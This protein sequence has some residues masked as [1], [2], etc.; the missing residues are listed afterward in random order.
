MFPLTR[1]PFWTPIFDPQPFMASKQKVLDNLLMCQLGQTKSSVSYMHLAGCRLSIG[2]VWQLKAL[3]DLSTQSRGIQH[4][5]FSRKP[6]GTDSDLFV[7]KAA[8]PGTEVLPKRLFDCFSS[9][10]FAGR[11]ALCC[12]F[13]F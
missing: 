4:P 7:R 3:P 6:K 8:S 10:M 1:V 5:F 13:Q 12:A 2:F 9:S 11:G